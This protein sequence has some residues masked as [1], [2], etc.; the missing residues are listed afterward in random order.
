MRTKGKAN[1]TKTSLAILVWAFIRG[2][3]YGAIE[4]RGYAWSEQ[5]GRTAREIE[6]IDGQAAASAFWRGVRIA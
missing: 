5:A 4:F 1:M 3:R 6:E 2:R